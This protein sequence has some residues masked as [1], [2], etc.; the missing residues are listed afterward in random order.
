MLSRGAAQRLRFVRRQNVVVRQRLGFVSHKPR[1]EDLKG[2]QVGLELFE[3]KFFH[4]LKILP[5]EE[6]VPVF[7]QLLRNDPVNIWAYHMAV[8]DY[9][10][11]AE[12]LNKA[13]ELALLAYANLPDSE[14][15]C[16]DLGTI[17]RFKGEL[18][19][20]RFFANRAAELNPGWDLPLGLLCELESVGER[21]VKK[22][23]AYQKRAYALCPDSPQCCWD[24]GEIYA[25]AGE[26][27]AAKE[28]ISQAVAAYPGFLDN[29]R[30]RALADEL[31]VEDHQEST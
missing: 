18:E 20:A 23:L 25:M 5:P 26:K 4:R 31:G 15:I 11:R 28:Y 30:N 19:Q 1:G 13:R 10:R 14:K 9:I 7:E 12:S 24:L 17:A 29:E 6:K 16:Y 8:E 22:M 3:L 27:K 21:D 2:L